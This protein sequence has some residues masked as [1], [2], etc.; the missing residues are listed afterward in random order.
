M[1]I[2]SILLFATPLLV[3]ALLLWLASW[4]RRKNAEL[5]AAGET[6]PEQALAAWRS[7]KLKRGFEI[8]YLGNLPRKGATVGKALSVL[9]LLAVSLA[10]LALV[11]ALVSR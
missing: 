6:T 2:Q 7:G 11:L 1:D 9:V 10:L 4:A 8:Y 5:N 3:G